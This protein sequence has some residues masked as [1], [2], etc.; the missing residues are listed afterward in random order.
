MFF[1]SARQAPLACFGS[2]FCGHAQP[3]AEISLLGIAYGYV[4]VLITGLPPPVRLEPKS[5]F[6]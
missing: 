3:A 2:T 6:H 4:N 1:R 5:S